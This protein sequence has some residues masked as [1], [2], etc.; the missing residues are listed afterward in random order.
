MFTPVVLA[1]DYAETIQLTDRTDV[2]LRATQT[3][4]SQT[5]PGAP[6][7]ATQP[8][9]SGLDFDNQAALLFNANN[10]TW[11]FSLV[12]SPVVTLENV[13]QGI[14]PQNEPLVLQTATGFAGWHSRRT[15][16]TLS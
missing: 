2:R 15:R 7:A 16:L 4:G 1:A 9:G 6:P 5:T 14:S 8:I 12:Y 10:R 11:R 3:T 13:Q